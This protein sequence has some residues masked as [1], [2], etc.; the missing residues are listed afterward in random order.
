MY[1]DILLFLSVISFLFHVRYIYLDYDKQ[2]SIS[3]IICNSVECRKK[4]LFFTIL[5]ALFVILYEISMND[6]ISV[7]LCIFIYSGLYGLVY[8]NT[9]YIIHYVYALI[10]FFSI[11]MYMVYF[12]YK[13]NHNILYFLL[14]IQILI[15]EIM[16]IELMIDLK[17]AK[18]FIQ[19]VIFIFIFF[20]FYILNYFL[21]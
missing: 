2:I 12:S 5:T 10:S 21:N 14:L 18:I 11:L 20:I 4:S 1:S 13:Y 15:F 16:V 8:T 19:E 6:N 9:K 17:K 7:I 3:N